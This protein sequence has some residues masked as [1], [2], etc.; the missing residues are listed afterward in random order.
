MLFFLQI[1][2]FL[3]GMGL[4][5]RDSNTGLHKRG[6]TP[7]IVCMGNTEFFDLAAR[8]LANIPSFPT[9]FCPDSQGCTESHYK[10]GPVPRLH[11]DAANEIR[12]LHWTLYDPPLQHHHIFCG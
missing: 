9:K 10:T 8:T 1:L 12:S 2:W 7:E 6:Q 11:N 4:I 3:I 5:C